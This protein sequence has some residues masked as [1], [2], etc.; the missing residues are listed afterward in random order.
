VDDWIKEVQSR[1]K[2]LSKISPPGRASDEGLDDCI[3]KPLT[4]DPHLSTRKI[5]KALNLS[6]T[7]VGKHLMKS[8]GM[9]CYHMRWVPHT[10]TEAQKAK[11][12]EM[13]GSMLQRLESHTASNFHFLWTGHESCMFYEYHH[14]TM[15]ATS[16]EEVDK[17][18]RPTHHDRKTMVNAL[19]NGPEEDSLNILP[20][21]RPM[22][23][24]YFAGGVIGGLEVSAISKREIHANGKRH[25]ILTTPP[26]TTQERSW[27]NWSSQ[28]SRGW[29]ICP[30]VRFGPI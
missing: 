8:L 28:G 9:K 18:E 12:R 20:R 7:T 21:S 17:H 26:Y 10:L 25:F 13:A 4:K 1:R 14:E 23:T 29:S 5:A 30:I 2:E 27:N 16:W 11:R 3:G 15:W 22:D 6:S 24:S 19:V